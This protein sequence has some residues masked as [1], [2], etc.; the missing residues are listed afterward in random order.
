MDSGLKAFLESGSALITD[1][2][3]QKSRA[4][5]MPKKGAASLVEK[6]EVKDWDKALISRCKD[7]K[8]P[9][10]DVIAEFKKII[11]REEELI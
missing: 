9:K 1:T 10:K 6:V 11:D 5:K 4:V 2:L 8:V 3:Q 7:E